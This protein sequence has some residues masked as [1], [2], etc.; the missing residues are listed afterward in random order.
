MQ[1]FKK[2]WPQ[3]KEFTHKNN[4]MFGENYNIKNFCKPKL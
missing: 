2:V 1:T 3:Y 4:A